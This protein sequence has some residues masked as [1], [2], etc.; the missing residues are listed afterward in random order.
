MR[1]S[2]TSGAEGLAARAGGRRLERPLS[3]AGSRCGV[4]GSE[5]RPEVRGASPSAWARRE[6][7]ATGVHLLNIRQDWETEHLDVPGVSHLESAAAEVIVTPISCL[8]S[9]L[10]GLQIFGVSES[11]ASDKRTVALNKC[12]LVSEHEKSAANRE[13]TR[14]DP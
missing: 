3:P 2:E 10:S 12:S 14:V 13:E 5:A 9:S 4:C 11:L 8:C 7:H 1:E 6:D